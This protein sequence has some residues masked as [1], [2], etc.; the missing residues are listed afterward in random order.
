MKGGNRR[1][2]WMAAIL[3]AGMIACSMPALSEDELPAETPAAVETGQAEPAKSEPAK[4]ETGKSEGAKEDLK[5]DSLTEKEEPLAKKPEDGDTPDA[6]IEEIEVD[7]VVT[8]DAEASAEPQAEEESEP[9]EA[10][11]VIA[12]EELPEDAEK[13][14]EIKDV[15]NPDR[16]ID[17]YM[18]PAGKLNYGDEVRLI[19]VLNGY[20]NCIYTLQWQQSADNASFRDIAGATGTSYRFKVTE[21]NSGYYWRLVVMITGVVG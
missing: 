2:K 4:D 12:E 17:I 7:A 1:M 18:E 10:E 5:E 3:A 9:E 16:R 13:I 20:D 14:T 21:E 19:A 8:E 15:L 6:P 11:E